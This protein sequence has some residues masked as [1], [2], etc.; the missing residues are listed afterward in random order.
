MSQ[1]TEMQVFSRVVKDTLAEDNKDLIED[2]QRMTGDC[3]MIRDILDDTYTHLDNNV[4]KYMVE[5]K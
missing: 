3:M 1:Y 4:L 2:V 5:Y